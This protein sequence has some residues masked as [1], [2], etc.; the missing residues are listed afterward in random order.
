MWGKN[1]VIK[2]M[3]ASVLWECGA[4]L[5]TGGRERKTGVFDGTLR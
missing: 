3:K 4:F 5:L 1:C 2:A